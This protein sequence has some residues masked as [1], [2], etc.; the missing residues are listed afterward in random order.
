MMRMFLAAMFLAAVFLLS[1]VQAFA[2]SA[3]EATY[4]NY[5][6]ACH[7]PANVMVSSPKAGRTADWEPRL[8]KGIDALALSAWTG[9]NAMPP[10]GN[11]E[12][13]TI[14]DL[15]NAI[16]FMSSSGPREQN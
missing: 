3:G 13:C 6:T 4:L 1:G 15:K 11:C 5:C 8:T 9:I 7:N 16:I 10:K 12:T 14:E 2:Q